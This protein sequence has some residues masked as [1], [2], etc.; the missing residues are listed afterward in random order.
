MYLLVAENPV[1]LRISGDQG[2]S[3][4]CH[5]V[6]MSRKAFTRQPPF[7]PFPVPTPAPEPLPMMMKVV[8]QFR[9]PQ[10]QFVHDGASGSGLY[11]VWEP[12]ICCVWEVSLI[13]ATI[14]ALRCTW[15]WSRSLQLQSVFHAASG[16]GLDG[17]VVP[18][19]KE[20]RRIKESC[21]K[22]AITFISRKLSAMLP[23]VHLLLL[24][25]K[26]HQHIYVVQVLIRFITMLINIW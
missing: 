10:L 15:K 18:L 23:V 3:T 25:R 6:R 19:Q 5:P 12:V 1:S 8:R 17:N 20:G 4:A 14:C 9:R 21:S 16:K 7:T 26:H 2:S 22:L 11:S 24:L 13:S